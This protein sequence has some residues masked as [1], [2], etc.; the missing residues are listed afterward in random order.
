MI[1]TL[2]SAFAGRRLGDMP[3]LPPLLRNNL[4]PM[5][6][7]AIA[8][9]AAVMM[10]LW[11]DK[12]SYQP[13]FGAREKVA[14]SDMMGVLEAEQIPF[15]VHP[16]SGQVLVP[17]SQLGKVRM[18]LAA[19]GVTAQLP[20]GLELMDK[21]DPLG[22]S[23]FVQDV[24]FRRGLEG[25]LAQSILTMD[26]ISSAR[27]HL[28]IAKSTSF[29]AS[30]GDKSS[31]SVVVAVKPGRNLT[32]EQIAA[33]VNLVSGSVAS[34]SPARVSLVDQ[35]GH[36]LSSRVDLADGFDAGSQ[37]DAN[38]K[39]VT[40]EVRA[41]VNE[42]LGPVLG[43]HNFKL[44]VTAD[45]DNDKV[46]E[47]QEKFGEAPK[48]TSEAMREE[49]E[50]S[51]MA[52]GVPGTLSNR[53]PVA[54]DPAA[55]APIETKPEDGSAR[56]NATTRQYAYDRSITQ[57]K[58]SRGRLR[59]LSVSVVLN[60]ASATNPKAGWNPAELANV[61][62]ILRSGLGIDAVRGDVLAVS[63]LSFP[64]AP[65]AQEWWQE[66]DNVV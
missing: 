16:D 45:V 50:K 19:K 60:N 44:S 6:V 38:A 5:L 2:K 24:R 22:V 56:K 64:A 28:A 57:I 25:E 12:A 4:T 13:V 23:Q 35:A 41:N 7:L 58:R 63:A 17:S 54:A 43:A 47:T 39:R 27:V 53:P 3:G 1:S 34:L 40:D 59:K 31:A 36:Y 29:V 10:F 52:L 15:R 32:D 62:K 9:T 8:I 51:R 49:M 55:A 20:A 65:V 33:I 42:L 48:V 18:L 66:R 14:A 30:D 37:G 26:A 46:E 61:D 11:Q 21:N